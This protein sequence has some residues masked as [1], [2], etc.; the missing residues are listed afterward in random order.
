MGSPLEDEI[1]PF[2][3]FSSP[4]LLPR[5]LVVGADLVADLVADPAPALMGGDQRALMA[6]D[7]SVH[8]GASAVLLLATTA[9]PRSA[10]TEVLHRSQ[11][12]QDPALT[13]APRA[14]VEPAQFVRMDLLWALRDEDPAPVEGQCA[15]M[16]ASPH[17]ALTA[18]SL[19]GVVVVEEA[20]AELSINFDFFIFIEQKCAVLPPI[21]S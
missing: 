21:S 17:C 16:L 2:S 14:V 15:Q 11:R 19:A 1:S 4:L 12:S 9:P 18:A 20:E 10:L 8:R 6:P 3:V 13:E 7:P 5:G